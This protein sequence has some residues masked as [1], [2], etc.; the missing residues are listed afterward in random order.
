MPKSVRPASWRYWVSWVVLPVSRRESRRRGRRESRRRGR[1]E[2][3]RRGRRESRRRG[4][5][6]SE[7]GVE[8]RVNS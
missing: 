4:R 2:S 7:V 3:R 6:D 1:R 8:W 5:R